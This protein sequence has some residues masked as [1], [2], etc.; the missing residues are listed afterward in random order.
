MTTM[1]QLAALD[2]TGRRF[3]R[4]VRAVLEDAIVRRW[5]LIPRGL[6]IDERTHLACVWQEWCFFGR[7][8][9]VLV[10]AMP[11]KGLINASPPVGWTVP[12][13]GVE[14]ISRVLLGGSRHGVI[15]AN[16]GYFATRVNAIDALLLGASVWDLLNEFMAVD[17][18]HVPPVV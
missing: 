2:W 12:P 10:V 5:L 6:T 16:K 13:E 18:K 11:R 3:T 17:P 4:R 14:V 7:C 15:Q 1:E 8:P 9:Q